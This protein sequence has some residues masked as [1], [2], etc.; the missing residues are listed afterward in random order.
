MV[1]AGFG[2][3]LALQ[4]RFTLADYLI[5]TFE[6]KYTAGYAIVPYSG[7]VNPVGGND[8]GNLY[9]GKFHVPQ[10]SIHITWGFGLD[11]YH[12]FHYKKDYREVV[13]RA[14]GLSIRTLKELSQ[15]SK[16]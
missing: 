4:F 14:S 9:V 7:K 11:F 2:G 5:G 10:H 8:R 12:S 3:Q 1:L 6:L 13:K 15:K 16:K